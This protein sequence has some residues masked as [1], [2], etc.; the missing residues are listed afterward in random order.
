MESIQL[1]RTAKAVQTISASPTSSGG[2]RNLWQ[3]ISPIR[4]THRPLEDAL[5]CEIAIVGGGLAGTS[6]AY[7]LASKG[8]GVVLLEA[9]ELG[10]GASSRA[11][12]IIAPQLTRH[13]PASVK[14]AL[15]AEP[16]ERFLRV[17]AESGHYLFDLIRRTGI[18]CSASQQGFL[19][20]V[21]G[22]AGA[23]RLARSVEQWQSLRS[24]L[25]LLDARRTRFLSGCAGYDAAVLDRSGG[26]LDPLALTQ[27]LGQLAA[28]AGAQLFTNSPVV[29]IAGSGDRWQL[30]TPR[31]QVTARRVVLC[32]HLGNAEL[33]HRLRG[34]V[35][36]LPVFQVATPRLDASLRSNIL[37]E[38][39]ALTDQEADVFSIRYADEGRLI[40]AY[41]AP[42]GTSLEVVEAA[43]NSR[44]KSAIPGFTNTSLEFMWHGIALVNSTLLP[45]IVQLQ[46]GLL[47]VQA[48]NG[49]GIGLNVILG[50]ELADWLSSF[51]SHEIGIP[52]ER[53]RKILGF[54]IAKHLPRLVTLI[55]RWQRRWAGS[56]P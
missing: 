7:H 48:C 46:D 37:P 14:R 34:T 9:A 43:V 28:A 11:A 53:P 42:F 39:Q 27:G 56:R 25:E 23:A 45:R 17:F 50:R 44:L 24:D 40:T 29:E 54:W 38:G 26:S 5:D 10:H 51:G 49:R 15:G 33:D 18:E 4:H 20:P 2:L 55:G 21:R 52:L 8:T 1:R 16:G 22:A 31:G 30:R 47:A 12:G 41:P 3:T 35:M 6:L 13:T 36:P 19:S 32:A